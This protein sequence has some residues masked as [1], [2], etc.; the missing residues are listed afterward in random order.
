[1]TERRINQYVVDA[2]VAVKWFAREDGSERAREVLRRGEAG[3]V[4]LHAPDLLL[5][6]V[7][8]AL[9]RGKGVSAAS[10]RDA[11][12]LLRQSCIEWHALDEEIIEEAALFT[13]RYG[14][15]FYDAAYAALADREDAVLLSANPKDHKQ[16][17]EVRV[18]TLSLS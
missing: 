10:V 17:R 8:N 16:I 14:I 13:E 2:S 11:L 4:T 7:G 3:E 9:A 18:Q 5:Y 6:E 1:M 15:T 12:G